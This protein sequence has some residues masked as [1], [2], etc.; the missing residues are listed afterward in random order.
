[1]TAISTS[2]VATPSAPR[3]PAMR[4][5]C[6][7][8]TRH[9]VAGRRRH[10]WPRRSRRRRRRRRL[11]E[12]RLAHAQRLQRDADLAVQAQHAQPALG[13][14]SGVRANGIAVE[15]IPD[16]RGVGCE[17]RLPRSSATPSTLSRPAGR[18]CSSET[19]SRRSTPAGAPSREVQLEHDGAVR[20]A[21]AR[22]RADH[23]GDLAA[24]STPQASSRCS[25][26]SLATSSRSSSSSSLST[27]GARRSPSMRSRHAAMSSGRA[28]VCSAR[29]SSSAG[30]VACGPSADQRVGQALGAEQLRR[31]R[32]PR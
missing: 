4:T 15:A 29:C 1:M 16:D 31:R 8:T 7:V 2:V 10:A 6:S 22:G 28:S 9:R 19:L 13:L 21:A 23:L 20:P 3:S 27:L 12:R 5:A 17:R 32:A 18:G 30:G 26:R 24:A 25:A 11:G 14:A